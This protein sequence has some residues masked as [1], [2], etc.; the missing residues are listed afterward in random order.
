MSKYIRVW[1]DNDWEF[2]DADFPSL[3][4]IKSDDYEVIEVP[5]GAWIDDIQKFVELYN[6]HPDM[7]ATS[8]WVSWLNGHEE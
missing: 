5:E 7:G 1:P 6:M 3:L 2:D 4:E 8:Y